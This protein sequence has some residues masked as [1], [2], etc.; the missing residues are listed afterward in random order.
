MTPE[1]THVKP[2]TVYRWVDADTVDVHVDLDF[3][4]EATL[5]FRLL[6]LDA[7]ERNTPEGKR[8]ID[9]VNRIVPAG[10]RIVVRTFKDG[11]ESDSFGRWLAEIFH[12]GESLNQYLLATGIAAPYRK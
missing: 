10:S 4:L 12:N 9:I 8:A 5:R 3:H 6:W 7:P 11:G 1:P 2:G